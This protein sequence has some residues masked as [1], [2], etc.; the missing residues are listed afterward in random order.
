MSEAPPLWW[1][2]RQHWSD[3]IS[4]RNKTVIGGAQRRGQLNRVSG[5]IR[6]KEKVENVGRITRAVKNKSRVLRL[7]YQYPFYNTETRT[8]EHILNEAYLTLRKGF[9]LHLRFYYFCSCRNENI[10]S[11]NFVGWDNYAWNSLRNSS[12]LKRLC[13]TSFF[14]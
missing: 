10:T 4:Y 5:R 9:G 13:R 11:L 6:D 1:V 7:A 3:R 8:A 12:D 2:L 14:V